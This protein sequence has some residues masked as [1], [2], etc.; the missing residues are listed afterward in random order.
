MKMKMSEINENLTAQDGENDLLEN[1]L[2]SLA[3]SF[4]LQIDDQTSNE[5]VLN[6]HIAELTEHNE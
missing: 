3:E 2:N 1:K 6:E 5:I 4:E